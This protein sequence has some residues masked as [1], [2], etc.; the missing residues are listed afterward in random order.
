MHR[1]GE[2]P[3]V[4][5]GG[6]MHVDCWIQQIATRVGAVTCWIQQSVSP[7][8]V[9]GF[10]CLFNSEV[11]QLISKVVIPGPEPSPSRSGASGSTQTIVHFPND[12][13]VSILFGAPEL[14]QTNF[15]DASTVDASTRRR[16]DAS[17]KFVCLS[18]V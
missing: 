15:S 6:K 1:G 8:Q 7:K 4:Q 3:P 2:S 11:D 9:A 14:R 13:A 17:K 12:M 10:S 5:L 18:S 16:V